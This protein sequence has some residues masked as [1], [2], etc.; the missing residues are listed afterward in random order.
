[1]DHDVNSRNE[2][3]VE[4]ANAVGGEEKYS[5][6]VF[7]GAKEAS[8]Q[9]VSLEILYFSLLHVDVC[10]IDEQYGSPRLGDVE[11]ANE[12][13]LNLHGVGTK[14]RASQREKGPSRIGCNTLCPT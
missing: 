9:V 4:S 1:M 3:F 2:R 7:H 8:D 10:F 11:P 12:L 6:V 14:V 13:R 5:L